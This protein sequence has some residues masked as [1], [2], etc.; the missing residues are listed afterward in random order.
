VISAGHA[1]LSMDRVKKL[2]I[3]FEEV[4][5]RFFYW[6]AIVPAVLQ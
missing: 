2:F 4:R 6:T 5:M 3:L 1:L